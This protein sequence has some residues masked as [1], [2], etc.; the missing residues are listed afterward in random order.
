MWKFLKKPFWMLWTV[1]PDFIPSDKSSGDFFLKMQKR[2]FV[3]TASVLGEKAIRARFIHIGRESIATGLILARASLGFI[4]FIYNEQF[5]KMVSVS[6]II[7]F[8]LIIIVG[9]KLIIL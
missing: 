7:S 9:I 1:L 2:N 6:M 3:F 4:A 5:K 8:K